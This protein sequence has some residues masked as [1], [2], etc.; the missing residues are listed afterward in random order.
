[1]F[2]STIINGVEVSMSVENNN[3]SF[4]VKGS[5]ERTENVNKVAIT[6]WLLKAFEVMKQNHSFLVCLAYEEDSYKSYRTIV[7]KKVG[8]IDLHSCLVWFSSNLPLEEKESIVFQLMLFAEE[9]NLPFLIDNSGLYVTQNI[10][11]FGYYVAEILPS[12]L[13]EQRVRRQDRRR[14]RIED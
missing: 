4:Q 2:L 14:R 5:F 7:Y 11:E 10:P 13:E 3:I 6:K 1:M 9:E 12:I 8:F